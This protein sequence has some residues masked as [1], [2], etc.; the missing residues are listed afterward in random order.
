[1]NLQGKHILIVEDFQ[2]E[3]DFLETLLIKNDYKVVSARD[4]I[5]ALEKLQL[6]A[7]DLII[8]DVLMPR[9]D[10]FQ[11][12]R[13]VKTDEKLKAIP[14]I[15]YT[16]QYTEV[17]DEEML[18]SLGAALYLVKPVMLHTLLGGIRQVLEQSGEVKIPT[19]A[20]QLN[21]KEFAAAHAERITL[22]LTKKIDELE[23]ER[24]NLQ[25][26]FEAA[27]VGMLL[28]DESGAVTRINP[29][30]TQLFGKDAA[31][32][33][34]GQIGDALG[35]LHASRDAA[36][37]GHTEVCPDCLMR[38]TF[39]E[40]LRTGETIR[41]VETSTRLI[42]NGVERQFYLSISAAPIVLKGRNHALLSFSDVTNR[43]RQEIEL[44]RSRDELTQTNFHL[45]EAVAQAN[46]ANLAK[47]E[48]LAN[49]SHEIRTPMNGVIG[50]IGLL[51]DTDL[52]PDQRRYAEIVLNSG[53]LL[54]ALL[55]DIL[56]LSKIEAG[57][58]DLEVLDFDLRALLDDFAAMVTLRAE[59]KGIEFI[60][61]AAPDV[62]SALRGDPG[63]LR[64]V[65]T[66]L[67]GNA[68]KFTSEGEISV[69]A[70]LVSKSDND[71][72]IRFS[73]KDSGIGISTEKQKILFQK[74]IQADPSTTRKYGGTGLGLAISKQLA[75]V[76]GGETGV[77]SKEGEGAEFWF[78]ARFARQTVDEHPIISPVGIRGVHVLVVDD[79]ATCRDV[80][81]IQ[82]AAW[83][84][85]PQ[86]APNGPMALQA[87]YM[88][89]D[90]GDPFPVAIVDM[91][92]PGMDGATLARIIKA[93]EKLKNTRLVLCSSLAQRGDAKR[94]QGIGFSGYLTK[95]VRYGE[96]IDC[97]SAVLAGMTVMEPEQPLVTRHTIRE[98]RLGVVRILLA[99]DNITNQQVAVGILK[100]LGLRADAVANGA[101][102]LK[103]LEA[104]PYDLVLM[105]VLMPEMDGLEA[106]RQIRNRQ[107]AVR[108][109]KIPIIAM[110]ANAMQGDREKC[111][112][113]G[114]NDYVS[115]PISPH[116]LAQ[117]LDRWLPQEVTAA[118]KQTTDKTE[119]QAPSV[120]TK[121]SEAS[122][123]DKAGMM[124]RMMDD[125]DLARTVLGGFLEDLPRLI[126]ALKGDLESGDLPRTERQAHTIKG[127]S[128]NVGGEALRA[129]AFDMEKAA[130]AGDLKSVMARLPE[131]EHQ[132]SRLKDVLYKYI[133]NN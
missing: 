23:S 59:E 11:L 110:T 98:M 30:V 21:E 20:H 120:S 17:E 126:E 62:P 36:G 88:A 77:E 124:V 35:C 105:D 90:A 14:F 132:V 87:L 53:E 50:M 74:F 31:A 119:H 67:M 3:R 51:L 57:K 116:A 55:N 1:M 16:A 4:G 32:M 114:M 9:M 131:L 93:D 96:I 104:L 102:A 128:A 133:S 127:A 103:A 83:G 42:I 28:I 66:N 72:L 97:L 78:T 38:R 111:I 6:A 10:G 118:L 81:T 125:E 108:N 70:S 129:V 43:K 41:G 75:E 91:Q 12:C 48:F 15:F 54:L 94:M 25:T 60:C 112:E 79:N 34:S 13:E 63:R 100:K 85:R 7:F 122:V 39:S 56:D 69:R 64:Q 76:M 117:A 86:E 52:N 24:A 130:R 46:I 45:N 58:L 65:L 123:F 73:V 92:M 95:P 107:S 18:R 80:L 68:V 121:E 84:V 22:K 71:V 5:E 99:E 109:H 47:S 61:A 33:I 44:T 40:V 49:M 82:L 106:T 27:Q 37:C 101:E 29:V 115:K 8:S 26:I 113:A 19:P 89:R 2:R